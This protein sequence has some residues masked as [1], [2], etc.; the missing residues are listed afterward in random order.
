[1]K[2]EE[3]DSRQ[4]PDEYQKLRKDELRHRI[5][6]AR[7]KRAELQKQVIELSKKRE[8]YIAQ[9]NKRLA[10]EGKSDAFDAKVAETLRTQAAKKGINY[11]Q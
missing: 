11:S 9:E 5:E 7:S 10:A 2:W 1:M 6:N 4:L 3:I 8:D